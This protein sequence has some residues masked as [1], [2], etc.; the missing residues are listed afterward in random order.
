[1]TTHPESIQDHH[2][3]ARGK[4]TR[5]DMIRIRF[6]PDETSASDQMKM[7]SRSKIKDE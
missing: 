5:K 4:G 2:Y 3:I 7:K 6:T 1:M